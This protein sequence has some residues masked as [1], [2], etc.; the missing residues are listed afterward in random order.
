MHA[1]STALFLLG[2]AASPARAEAKGIVVRLEPGGEVVSQAPVVT[3]TPASGAPVSVTLN[4]DGQPPDVAAS[5]GRWAAVA[6]AEGSAFS[7]GVQVGSEQHDAGEV[8]WSSSASARDLVLTL[9]WGG[10]TALASSPAGAPGEGG[11]TAD[12]GTTAP[13]ASTAST[14]TATAAPLDP[15]LWGGVGAGVLCLL[16]GLGLAVRN[17]R[18]PLKPVNLERI[19]EPP[20]LGPGTPTLHRGLSVWT[21]PPHLR[22]RLTEGLVRTMACHHRVLV[23]LPEGAPCPSTLGGP[24][25]FTRDAT[26]RRLEDHL[27]DMVERPGLPITALWVVDA[28]ANPQLTAFADILEPDI[29]GIVLATTA[30]DGRTPDVT[31]L[32]VDGSLQLQTRRGAI[33]LVEG[34]TGLARA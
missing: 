24:A 26:I 16:V 4:D 27:V 25:Y 17:A 13:A 30:P 11:P 22:D 20:I 12:P 1:L 10:V 31:V 14:T 32:E 28:P 3:L 29:G 21:V 8:T 7:V 19:P 2:T 15:V 34:A 5:D 18:P 6:F 33:E 9:T 23:C